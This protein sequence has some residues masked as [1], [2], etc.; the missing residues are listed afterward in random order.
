M[1]YDNV[2][3]VVGLNTRFRWII[4]PGSDLFLVYN[5]NMERLDDRFNALQRGA[6][7]KV[8]YTHRF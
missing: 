5:H 6:T 8:T 2:S 3:R 4:R 7:S 1:Q